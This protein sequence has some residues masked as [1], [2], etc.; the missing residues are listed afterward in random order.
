MIDVNANGTQGD[1]HLIQ[2]PGGR[3]VLV[4]TG[5]AVCAGTRLLPFLKRAGV[6][7]LDALFVTHP[8]YDH[9]E[10][11]VPLLRSGL[12][13]GQILMN[14]IKDDW[15]RKEWW[16]GKFADVEELLLE[17]G[18]R[19]I[20]VAGH[21]TWN[22]YALSDDFHIE[23]IQCL[24]ADDFARMNIAGDMNDMSLV[25]VL[26]HRGRPVM[27]YP[28]DINTASGAMLAAN[29]RMDFTCDVLKFPHHGA[30]SF[31]GV[32][33]MEALR[34]KAVLYP[35]P[36]SIWDTDRCAKARAMAQRLGAAVYSNACDGDV[37]VL[38]DSNGD[39]RV[40]RHYL[41]PS[42]CGGECRLSVTSGM[43]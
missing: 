22:T 24:T 35:T 31:G 39:W 43:E 5:A 41:Q 38:F 6:T 21:D 26:K 23:K 18:R 20:P 28:A 37:A 15:F 30:E 25:A 33:V 3:T 13:V 34:P 1:A 12:P 9:Y 27:F 17:A 10:S 32:P 2:A 14:P 40:E 36:S 8:H 16:A 7:R 29:P 4:D 42:R 11:V 19:N